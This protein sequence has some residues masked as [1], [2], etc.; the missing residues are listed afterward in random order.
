MVKLPQKL[1]QNATLVSATNHRVFFS[2]GFYFKITDG[3]PIRTKALYNEAKVLEAL[4]IPHSLLNETTLITPARGIPLH[5]QDLTTETVSAIIKRAKELHALVPDISFKEVSREE[6]LSY[7]SKSAPAASAL[8]KEAVVYGERLAGVAENL[9]PECVVHGDLHLTN[10]VK[11]GDSF[12]LIDFE[13]SHLSVAE[14]DWASLVISLLLATSP[15][16]LIHVVLDEV[17]RKD[18]FDTALR[19]KLKTAMSWSAW[20][21]DGDGFQRRKEIADR[22][23]DNRN[24]W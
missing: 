18:H 19:L 12:N 9:P 14:W 2:D 21:R 7:R 15:K 24:L 6:I 22:L 16:A 3:E 5:H 20:R 4:S 13:S 11:Q 1:E 10:V 23:L 17:E 8:Y